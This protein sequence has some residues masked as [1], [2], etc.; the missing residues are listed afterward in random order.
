MDKSVSYVSFATDVNMN[1]FAIRKMG[2]SATTVRLDTEL[3]QKFDSV[4]KSMGMNANV[5]FNIFARAVV[6]AKG[7]PFAVESSEKKDREDLL[8]AFQAIR[9][10]SESS[11]VNEISEEEIEKE[12]S[13]YRSEK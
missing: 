4:C 5:A 10:K 9:E 3:K 11:A 7:I 6:R 12:I 1:I 2:Y 13:Q 8:A